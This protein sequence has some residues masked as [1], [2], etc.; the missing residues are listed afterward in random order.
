VKRIVSQNEEGSQTLRSLKSL[1]YDLQCS[2][3]SVSSEEFVESLKR[4]DPALKS[5]DPVSF[6]KKII[7]ILTDEDESLAQCFTG[8]V[9]RLGQNFNKNSSNN[10]KFS[11][12]VLN[13]DD[14]G[15]LI[16]S[17]KKYFYKPQEKSSFLKFLTFPTVL[18]FLVSQN[19]SQ[20][21]ESFP[22]IDFQEFYSTSQKYSLACQILEIRE[23]S[24]SKFVL[25]TRNCNNCH[26]F[27]NERVSPVL[28]EVLFTLNRGG[29]VEKLKVTD[30]GILRSFIETK[31]NVKILIYVK[32][33]NENSAFSVV[34]KTG[35]NLPLL[36]DKE[37]MTEVHL[38]GLDMIL[39]WKGPGVLH[40]I[41]SPMFQSCS[42]KLVMPKGFR[43]KDLRSELSSHILDDYRLWTFTPGS[44][45]WEL[46]EL[47]LNDLVSSDRAVFIEVILQRQIFTQVLNHWTFVFSLDNSTKSS[48][49]NDLTDENLE[50]LTPSS[51]KAIVFL[52]WYDW[53]EGDPTLTLFKMVTL[54]STSNMSQI[55]QDLLTSWKGS[56]EGASKMVLHLEKCKVTEYKNKENFLHVYTYRADENYELTISKRGN[57]GV[58]HVIIDNGDAFIGE[59]PPENPSASYLDAKKYISTFFSS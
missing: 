2:N 20:S 50:M 28:P 5:Y 11:E 21:F 53:N 15:N 48:F 22:E 18:V 4:K 32:T 7:K 35:Q 38:I 9:E 47:K 44:K 33:E 14:S 29:K 52:K 46:K 26:K 17:L 19:F 57:F 42:L 8:K 41:V 23:K 39:G 27:D 36:L 40:P 45:N 25:F 10:E 54:T 37:V 12:I 56:S 30:T 58:R 13:L 1:F 49:E 16:E 55:R 3:F 31:R 34:S 24:G 43:G 6:I 51:A 59:S